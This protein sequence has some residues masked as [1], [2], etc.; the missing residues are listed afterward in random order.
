VLATGI[1]RISIGFDQEAI[2]K[3][4]RSFLPSVLAGAAAFLLASMLFAGGAHAADLGA[5]MEEGDLDSGFAPEAP[6]ASS[7]RWRLSATPYAWLTWVQGDQTVRGRSVEI[8]VNPI[9]LLEDLDGVPFMGYAEARNGRFAL[10]GDIIYAPLGFD[11]DGVRSRRVGSAISGSLSASLDLQLD[12]TI[13][14]AGGAYEIAKW[15]PGSGTTAVDVLAGARYWRQEADLKLALDATLDVGDLSVT[16]SAA[17][18]R[19]GTVDWVDPVI[20]AVMR[21]NLSQGQ[22][23]IL[24]GDIGGFGAGSEFSWNVLAAYSFEIC[25]DNG[26]TY[27]GVLGYRLLDVDYEEGSGRSR[28]EFDVLQHGPLSGLTVTF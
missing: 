4:L 23:V 27:S 1:G 14:E 22:D 11:R 3:D 19:S 8:D 26:V 20:G 9:E 7:S 12:Q 21:H 13:I 25:S 2:M 6:P 18:A 16:R 28:Y 24:R 10:Y 15:Q 5:E 17:I